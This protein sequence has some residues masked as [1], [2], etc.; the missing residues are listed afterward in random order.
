MRILSIIFFALLICGC[1]TKGDLGRAIVQ[2]VAHYGG[3]TRT[4]AAIPELRG[5]WSIKS[6]AEGFQAHLSGVAIA[7]IQSFMQQVYGDPM[8]NTNLQGIW[9]RAAD[10][11][12]AIQFF[13]EKNGVS[14]I[15]QRGHAYPGGPLPFRDGFLMLSE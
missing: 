12:V 1:Q 4:T 5:A 7:D 10:I 9:Y 15:C 6:D 8:V 14:F 11:G 13:G 2:Q 3:H